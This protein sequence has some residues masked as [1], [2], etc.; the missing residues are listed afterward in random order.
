MTDRFRKT[1]LHGSQ[2]LLSGSAFCASAIL[3]NELLGAPYLCVS[4]GEQLANDLA[5]FALTHSIRAWSAS[6]INNEVDEEV[7]VVSLSSCGIAAEVRHK[8]AN[9]HATDP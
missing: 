4:F 2:P 7:T 3:L 5:N 6:G 8:A 9:H 1:K